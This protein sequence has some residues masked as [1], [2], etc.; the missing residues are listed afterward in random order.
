MKKNNLG[1]IAP[2]EK[3][4]GVTNG[5]TNKIVC[6]SDVQVYLDSGWVLG[7]TN[8]TE[9]DKNK[10]KKTSKKLTGNTVNWSKEAKQQRKI[11]NAVRQSKGIYHTPKGDFYSSSEARTA[12][13]VKTQDSIINRCIKLNL[14]VIGNK[15][16]K[17]DIKP[18]WRG[19][20]WETLGWGF[21]PKEKVENWDLVVTKYFTDLYKEAD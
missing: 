8:I 15:V 13:G 1:A 16:S 20:T 5:I 14:K 21:T 12:N 19:K 17:G 3:K 9:K 7:K 6:L 11:D 2:S 4:K 10:Y 18:E